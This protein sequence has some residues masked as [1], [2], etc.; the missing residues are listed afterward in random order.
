M[1]HLRDVDFWLKV[2]PTLAAVIVPFLTYLWLAR[3][4]E[5]YKNGLS[6]EL[7][8]HKSQLQAAF[9]L[10]FFQF[11]TRYSWIQQRRGEAIEKLYAL[12]A[13]VQVDLQRWSAPETGGLTKPAEE[14]FKDTQEHLIALADF[15][16]EKRIFFDDREISSYVL[17]MIAATQM[18][19]NEQPEI[20]SAKE[21]SAQLADFLK[22]NS[23]RLIRQNIDP[24]MANLRGMLL[25]ILEAEAP[26]H[27]LDR[28]SPPDGGPDK[29]Q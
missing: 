13:R 24:L 12:L 15:F 1:N 4:I 5:H 11:Q 7:E 8:I 23:D 25:M 22:E 9:Q 29:K 19:Y 6:K 20:E 14:C 10:R 2:G 28:T 27:Q 17:E 16:D 21:V 26:V 18:L 3:R